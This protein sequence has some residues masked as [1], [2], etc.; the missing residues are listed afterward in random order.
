MK[1]KNI[2]ILT[3]CIL[4]IS[5]GNVFGATYY[6]AP[7]GINSNNGTTITEPWRTLSYAESKLSAGDTVIVR[8]GTYNEYF[9]INVANT[10]FEK[11]PG[12][13]VI[14][15]GAWQLPAST[16]V[17]T[18]NSLAYRGMIDIS[19]TG[20]TIDGFEIMQSNGRGIS[21][22]SDNATIKNC[23]IHDVD[24]QCIAVLAD[25]FIIEDSEIY[26]GAGIVQYCSTPY[27]ASVC[28]SDGYG[29]PSTI[30]VRHAS[31]GI[32]RRCKIYDSY[33]EGLNIDNFSNQVTVEY[34]E[35][36]GNG[37][38]QL[39]II[40]CDN[41]TARYNL[42]YGVNNNSN[43]KPGY[44]L[45]IYLNNEAQWS[46]ADSANFYLHGN[47]IANTSTNMLIAG[48]TGRTVTN[49]LAYNNTL[50]SG[51][52]YN[53]MCNLGTGSGHV[54]KNNIVWGG[55]TSAPASLVTADSNLWST[56]P[57]SDL[58]GDNDPAYAI[59]LLAK[60]SGWSNITTLSLGDFVLK[61]ESPAIDSGDSSIGQAY[62]DIIDVEQSSSFPASSTLLDQ[63][64]HGLGW[65]I[66]A[67]IYS[68]FS[69]KSQA[70]MPPAA[71]SNL[72]I[73]ALD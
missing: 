68:S 20:V 52:T 60:E 70:P 58:K 30:I 49:V 38:I 31:G 25:N 48:S 23:K 41:I 8:G 55:L 62:D 13:S 66:G 7:N 16:H 10:T 46:K 57:V 2:T 61:P 15:D 27:S 43:G 67:D 9:T 64:A 35:I 73:N 53:F 54:F 45:G 22:N 44:G 36:Y 19:A 1:F 3:A 29:D 50:V 21:I 33:N 6:V 39:Y 51:R 4:M 42:I 26:R 32:I 18:S 5:A 59:P 65:E 11:Y 71:P 63:D 72:T 69:S 28:R 12:E 34:C 14:I 47:F 56:A 17:L 40:S 37:K 24:R